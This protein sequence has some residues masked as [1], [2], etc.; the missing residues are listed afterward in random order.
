LTQANAQK[1]ILPSQIDKD[2]LTPRN[3]LLAVLV[4]AI[5][6][7]VVYIVDPTF[8]GLLRRKTEGF[9]TMNGAMNGAMNPVMS[10]TNTAPMSMGG[11]SAGA[12]NNGPADEALVQG[13]SHNESSEHETVSPMEPNQPATEG[14][15]NLNPS[16]MPFPDSEKP[17]NC[18]PKNQLTAPEL[19]PNDP[20]S[21]WA[22]VNPQGAGDIAG[23]NFLNA[24]ALIG[25]NT[26]GQSLRNASWDLR[27]EPPNPQQQVSPWLQ[28]TISP[29]LQRRPLE[30]A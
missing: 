20:N 22:Q 8:G 3:I 5:L 4:V 25:V 17:A 23:K 19:L 7:G 30:I 29:D 9:N 18:Y 15:Q 2:M 6:V 10:G 28:T 12:Y 24:G 26:V 14:F 21:K 1:K 11:Q 27:S 13:N 16:P